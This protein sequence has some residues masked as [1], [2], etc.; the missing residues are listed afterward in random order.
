MKRTAKPPSSDRIIS[1]VR[2]VAD[3]YSNQ[4]DTTLALIEP[5]LMAQGLMCVIMGKYSPRFNSIIN[6]LVQMQGNASNPIP[7]N[8]VGLIRRNL[9]N[10]NS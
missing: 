10:V 5:A 4:G 9:I 3:E 1:A 8:K 2:G 6:I 7:D